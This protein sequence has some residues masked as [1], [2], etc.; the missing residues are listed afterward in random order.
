MHQ[1]PALEVME[2]CGPLEVACV[3]RNAERWARNRAAIQNADSDYNRC[4]CLA[5]AGQPNGVTAAQCEA[6]F[7]RYSGNLAAPEVTAP[8][9]VY[10]PPAP[11]ADT[12]AGWRSVPLTTAVL[13][14]PLMPPPTG[15][16]GSTG[17]TIPS[18]ARSTPTPASSVTPATAPAPTGGGGGVAV[19]PG[20][21][22][23]TVTPAAT[24]AVAGGS[25]TIAGAQFPL[26]MLAAAAGA[27]LLLMRGR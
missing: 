4:L 8:G 24:P 6:Q 11:I 21:A 1:A 22:P 20:Q 14:P 10:V 7:P 9:F 17:Y 26:W 5:A 27:A 13:A 2:N 12:A 23:Y 25:V 15:G 18:P 19:T 16:G 3:N